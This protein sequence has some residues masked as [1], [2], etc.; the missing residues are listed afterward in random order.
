[1]SDNSSS[2]HYSQPFET[3]VQH[4]ESNGL[5][6][7]ADRD[8]KSVQLFITGDYARVNCSCL[9]L[10]KLSMSAAKSVRAFSKSLCVRRRMG[11][12]P[13]L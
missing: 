13:S 3:L 1:M 7:L 10:L 11:T 12:K 8:S 2:S 6:F 9:L 4:F 5:K